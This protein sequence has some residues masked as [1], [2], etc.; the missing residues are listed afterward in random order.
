MLASPTLEPLPHIEGNSF[1]LTAMGLTELAGTLQTDR[2]L[3]E[4]CCSRVVVCSATPEALWFMLAAKSAALPCA[5]DN[6]LAMPPFS[7][8]VSSLL[9]GKRDIGLRTSPWLW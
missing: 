7:R 3:S 6:H 5:R 4:Q 8:A 1:F 2:W 9:G